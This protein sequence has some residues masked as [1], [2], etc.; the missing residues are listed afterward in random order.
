MLL[1]EGIYD[2]VI[3][4]KRQ[5]VEMKKRRRKNLWQTVWKSIKKQFK[6]E[7]LE[8]IVRI[9]WCWE[10][11]NSDFAM[12]GD[13]YIADASIYRVFDVKSGEMI[14][15]GMYEFCRMEW[16][17]PKKLFGF[18]YGYKFK[19]G[20]LYRVLVREYISEG[21]E[22]CRRYYLEQVLEENVKIPTLD[23]IRIFESKFEEKETDLTVLI[24]RRINGWAIMEVNYR[25]PK[26]VFIA[27]I[28]HN[29]NELSQSYGVLTWME[30]ESKSKIKFNFDDLETY[31]VRV[32]KSKENDNSYLLLNVI[33]KVKDGRLEQLK[34]EYLKPVVIRN[35]FGEFE[36]DKDFNW[37]E[38]KIGY[39][40]DTC[41]VRL[42]VEQ[43]ETNVE[44]QLSKLGEITKDL[45]AWDEK[46]KKYATQELFDLANDWCEEEREITEEEFCQRIC[47]MGI[48][49][50]LDGSIEVELDNDEMFTDHCIVID[51]DENGNFVSADIEG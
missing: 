2:N 20:N 23:P 26:A 48:N 46:V 10:K 49:I 45:A 24:Q 25:V 34:E 13:C 18:K 35:E 28:D 32:R 21:D 42:S 44:K 11:G 43:G 47:V 16:L 33:K 6:P 39:L 7:T 1:K 36:L 15:D 38:G 14:E 31:H 12:L 30:K 8:L 5:T 27:S 4:C 51:I 19:K 9:R 37:F 41:I 50:D 40:D 3:V 29:T 17:A 22:K